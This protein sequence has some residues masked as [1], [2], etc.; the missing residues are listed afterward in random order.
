MGPLAFSPRTSGSNV[1]TIRA[2]VL[3]NDI[4][5][6]AMKSILGVLFAL[7]MTLSLAGC[8]VYPDDPWCARHPHKC[9]Y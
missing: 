5:E 6:A 9:G 8:V 4:W 1:E 3:A 7:G 2:L